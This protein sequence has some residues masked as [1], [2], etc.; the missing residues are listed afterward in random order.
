MTNDLNGLEIEIRDT[1]LITEAMARLVY[2]AHRDYPFLLISDIVEIYEW[3]DISLLVYT[4]QG[5][6]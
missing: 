1:Y 6:Y 3:A 4:N 5:Y 2:K